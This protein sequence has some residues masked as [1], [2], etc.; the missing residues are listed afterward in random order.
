MEVERVARFLPWLS[1]ASSSSLYLLSIDK[2]GAVTAIGVAVGSALALARELHGSPLAV[3]IFDG[4][5]LDIGGCLA[6][7]ALLLTMATQGFDATAFL[8]GVATYCLAAS[9]LAKPSS[10]RIS[11][12]V[13]AY[14]IPTTTILTALINDPHLACSLPLANFVGILLYTDIAYYIALYRGRTRR[15][16]IVGGAGCMDALVIAPAICCSL[17]MLLTS[18]DFYTYLPR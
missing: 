1:L 18:I 12:N 17:L 7:L 5:S 6:P 16:F 14:S 8:L 13:L 15:S 10:S 4:I 11:I 2:I 9:L 3:K